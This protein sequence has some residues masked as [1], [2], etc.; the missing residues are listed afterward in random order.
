MTTATNHM[1]AENTNVFTAENQKEMETP[2]KT[3]AY[4]EAVLKHHDF[5][6]Y[7]KAAQ[8]KFKKNLIEC[9]NKEVDRT[10]NHFTLGYITN[11]EKDNQIVDIWLHAN[12]LLTIFVRNHNHSDQGPYNYN[13]KTDRKE[14]KQ[15]AR[16][17]YEMA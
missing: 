17:K 4:L 14:M 10:M 2:Q 11:R 7:V 13:H 16:K 1:K 9:T 12:C 15:Q 6:Y 8:T 3:A 5:G